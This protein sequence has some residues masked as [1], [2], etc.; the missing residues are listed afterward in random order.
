M[1]QPRV[2]EIVTAAS[3]L[4]MMLCSGIVKGATY[5][6][7]DDKGW[8]FNVESWTN[9]KKFLPGDVLIF[10]YD[11]T[12]HN[13]VSVD[14]VSYD[15]CTVGSNFQVFESGHDEVTLPNT[16]GWSYFI[17]NKTLGDCNNKMKIQV[18]TF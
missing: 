8:S 2:F 5:T 17:G 11:P 10:N 9:G 1:A 15:T 14:Q 3:L 16:R 4:S 6:V 13:V 18:S 7:G 12:I